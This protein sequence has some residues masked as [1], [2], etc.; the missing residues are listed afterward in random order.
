MI[1][2]TAM[3]PQLKMKYHFDIF[4]WVVAGWTKDLTRPRLY[5]IFMIYEWVSRAT[6]R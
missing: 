6:C 4:S 3:T 5:E 1:K 2:K